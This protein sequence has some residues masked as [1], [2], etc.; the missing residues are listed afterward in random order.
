MP[1]SAFDYNL[2]M[3]TY[4]PL[5][6]FTGLHHGILSKGT[7]YKSFV[8]KLDFKDKFDCR[9]Q[10]IQDKDIVRKFMA[11]YKSSLSIESQKL[12]TGLSQRIT[13]KFIIYKLLTDRAIFIGPQDIFYIVYDL[14]DPFYSLITDDPPCL[15]E[16][17]IVPFQ[18]R[19]VYDGFLQPYNVHFGPAIRKSMREQYKTAKEEG[20]IVKSL[21][22]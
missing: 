16:A 19:I 18:N 1:L 8:K 6:H 5:L 17:S 22:T 9:Q 20:L 10:L 12:L 14:S 21:N 13:G 4:L 2:F 7:S 11:R 15:V 3:D